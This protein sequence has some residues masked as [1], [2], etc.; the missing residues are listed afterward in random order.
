MAV[1]KRTYAGQGT[2]FVNVDLAKQLLPGTFEFA[3][4]HIVDTLDISCF[5][6][7]Y[8]NDET[9]APAYSPAVLLKILFYCYSNGTIS[10]RKI[11]RMCEEHIILKALSGDVVPHFT[12]IASFVSSNGE[13]IKKVFSQVLLHCSE[14]GLIQGDI[15]AIDGCKLPS[16]AA[17][18]FSPQSGRAR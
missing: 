7:A 17:S 18:D 5:D 4:N 13:A 11:Q 14:L 1:Y 10:S 9:G 12:T 16:N 2:L 6:P 3:L 15:F 8:Q